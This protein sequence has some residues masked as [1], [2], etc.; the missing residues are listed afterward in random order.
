MSLFL[1]FYGTLFKS[2]C[3]FNLSL[4]LRNFCIVTFSS[5][6]SA[7]LRTFEKLKQTYVMKCSFC[8]FAVFPCVT[9]GKLH[10]TADKP[11][12]IFRN[13]SEQKFLCQ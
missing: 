6:Q 7:D 2:F 10:P 5:Y 9:L 12:G 13:F 8:K 11:H 1:T 4:V 3:K